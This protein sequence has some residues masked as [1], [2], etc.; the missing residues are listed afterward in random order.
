MT[1]LTLYTTLGCHLCERLEAEFA[2]LSDDPVTLERV[3]IADDD[4]LLAR[5]G[6]RIP[7]L[8]DM[9]GHE[10]DRGFDPERLTGWL[11]ERGC[12]RADTVTAD[13]RESQGGYWRDGRR[14][15]G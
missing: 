15:L 13:T 6:E 9:N 10:L 14:Y 3:D 12:L 2:R 8:A 1:R 4:E 11:A 7:V 5:Y